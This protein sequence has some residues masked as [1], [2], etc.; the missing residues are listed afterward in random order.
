MLRLTRSWCLALVTLTV[1]LLLGPD[2]VA[3]EEPLLT[4]AS[5]DHR[6]WFYDPLTPVSSASPDYAASPQVSEGAHDLWFYFGPWNRMVFQYIFA[7]TWKIGRVDD[8][9]TEVRQL[10]NSGANEYSPRLDP[11]ANH[12]VFVTE[13]D[14]NPEIYT[15]TV[16]GTELRR[17]T[18]HPGDDYEPTWSPDGR[19]IAFATNRYG[20]SD[21]LLIDSEGRNEQR[22]TSSGADGRMPVFSPD[23]SHIA[24]MSTR[25]GGYRIWVMNVDGSFPRQLSSQ[26]YSENPV[27]SP[28]GSM[29][30]FDA[31]G[32][33]DGWQ[34]LWVMNADGTGEWM[35]TNGGPA[36]GYSDLLAGTW[37]P[38]SA[39]LAY[40][41]ITWLVQNNQLYIWSSTLETQPLQVVGDPLTMYSGYSFSPDWRSLDT[42]TPS[43]SV[44]PLPPV[45]PGPIPLSWSGSDV[46][47]SGPLHYSIQAREGDG[48]W[49]DWI[50]STTSTTG[51]FPGLGGHT[52]AFRSRA[53]DNSSLQEDWP[54]GPDATTTVENLPPVVA[55]GPLPRFWRGELTV[56]WYGTDPGGSG[57]VYY[58]LQKSDDAVG[59]WQDWVTQED[60]PHRSFTGEY[61]HTYVFRVRGVDGA[62]NT[63]DWSDGSGPVSFYSSL[64]YGQIADN[65]G[66]PIARARVEALPTALSPVVSSANGDYAAYIGLARQVVTVTATAD[67]FGQTLPI[68][69]AYAKEA[70][71][72]LTL[73]PLDDVF[74]AGQLE[75]LSGWELA[76]TSPPALA[77]DIAAVHSGTSGALLSASRLP[78]FGQDEVVRGGYSDLLDLA[79]TP[80]GV[81]HWVWGNELGVTYTFRI[82]AGEW[83]PAER[84]GEAASAVALAV[85]PGGARCVV[86]ESGGQ[87]YSRFKPAGGVWSDNEPLGAGSEPDLAVHGETIHLLNS[88]ATVLQLRTRSPAQ[89][90]SEPQNLAYG[91][92]ARLAVG[93]DGGV[94]V[95]YRYLAAGDIFYCAPDGGCTNQNETGSRPRIAVDSSGGVHLMWQPTDGQFMYYSD[96]PAGSASAAAERIPGCPAPADLAVDA[97][98]NAYVVNRMYL[99]IYLHIKPAGAPWGDYALVGRTN[100]GSPLIAVDAHSGVHLVTPVNEQEGR[101]IPGRLQPAL[102]DSALH[103]TLSVPDSL[104]HPTLSL[105]YRLEGLE[106]D[107]QAG[108]AVSL[109]EA[110]ACAEIVT[111]TENSP[112]WSHAWADLSAW[113]GRTVTLTARIE[114]TGELNQTKAWLDEITVGSWLT[115]MVLGF[116]PARVE[117][118]ITSTLTIRADNLLCALEGPQVYVGETLVENTLCQ[119]EG[120]VAVTLP[121]LPPGDYGVVVV[122]PGGQASGAPDPLLVGRRAAL[123]ILM[124]RWE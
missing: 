123:P 5:G 59:E 108:L 82:S 106:Q 73:P 107:N 68:R 25:S 92:Q 63:A 117:A 38:D 51:L 81:V 83:A 71:L 65:R 42:V 6:Y 60:H 101:Y 114:T 34:D 91:D 30:C 121:P 3:A 112:G 111:A 48:P 93:P 55:L 19:W 96:L 124:K 10:V 41:H 77:T 29:I 104:V 35:H 22:L 66:I 94:H 105:W 85:T 23:G 28:D 97:A 33:L 37:A 15:A 64:I 44:A 70:T 26:P 119:P 103:R 16:D 20:Q 24:F 118:G 87:L 122:N 43:S 11:G 18:F 39:R 79:V 53:L 99:G 78:T 40:T 88:A 61:G 113:S 56:R 31:D 50:T 17:I 98:G 1:M 100:Y 2:P 58:D 80:D 109:C 45:S 46:P 110:S 115:P 62:G 102:V 52:Y 12:I 9:A 32:N 54:P 67:G 95:V 74:P 47:W 120:T 69:V 21:I 14:G 7:D 4:R 27:W 84:L 116:E 75:T 36:Y 86:R 76:G 89:G 57:I 90:W 49:T 72:D 8:G 13:R